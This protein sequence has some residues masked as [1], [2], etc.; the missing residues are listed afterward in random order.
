MRYRTRLLLTGLLI[1]VVLLV[2]CSSTSGEIDELPDVPESIE[3]Q[4]FYRSRPGESLSGSTIILTRDSSQ[5]TVEFETLAFRGQYS[6]DEFEGWSVSITV[7]P[8]ETDEE[9]VR[10][11]YQLDGEQGLRNQFIG[12][13][14]FTGLV[15]VYHPNSTGEMQ[16]FCAVSSE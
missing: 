15:Y 6:G 8:T 3:C 1:V 2:G 11:L 12:G 7:T 9:M 13:H 16:Y 5:E 10:Q 14:G 4:V